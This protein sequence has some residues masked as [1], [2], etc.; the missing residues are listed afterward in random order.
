MTNNWP[1]DPELS[2]HLWSGFGSLDYR[3]LGPLDKQGRRQSPGHPHLC[4]SL[5][6]KQARA[7]ASL[8]SRVS[9]PHQHCAS[10]HRSLC[11]EVLGE[12]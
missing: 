10:P 5:G 9:V 8:E 12:E 4:A 1:P 3:F 7:E 11:M 2:C 6:L